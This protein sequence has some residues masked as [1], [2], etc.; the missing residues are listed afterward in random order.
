MK[1][2][3]LAGGSGTRLFPMSRKKHPKQ[4]LKIINGKSLFQ[5]TLERSL[6]VANPEDLI[7]ITNKEYRFHVR[8]QLSFPIQKS[9]QVF[10]L[11]TKCVKMWLNYHI[12]GSQKDST[13]H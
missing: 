13:L 12:I 8:D 5:E 7:I 2:V 6:L 9:P 4:F 3:I 10:P 11:T 1:V